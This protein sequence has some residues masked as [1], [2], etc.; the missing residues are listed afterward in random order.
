MRTITSISH[1]LIELLRKQEFV[2]A[3]TELFSADAESIDPLNPRPG[4]LKGL[5]KLIQ[6]EEQFLSKVKIHGIEISEAIHAGSYF[7]ISLVMSFHLEGK[8]RVIDEICVYKVDQGAII[9]QQFF[10]S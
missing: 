4:G 10:I 1:R 8:E 9:S 6:A 7:S 2:K 3:Y 5:S